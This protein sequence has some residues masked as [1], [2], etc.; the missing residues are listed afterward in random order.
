MSLLSGPIKKHKLEG[1]GAASAS[2]AIAALSAHPG[3]KF[4][5][6]GV[7]GQ[8]LFFFL[9]LLFSSFAS[10]GLVLTNVG[11]AKLAVILEKN[12]YTGSWDDAEKLISEIR[13]TG[14]DLTPEEIKSIDA[15]VIA[16]FQKFGKL[17]NRKKK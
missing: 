5:T 7:A 12:E 13:K 15:P 9:K 4:L 11:A 1:I 16:A 6:V 2:T 10:V 14:R 17:G 3:A 8:I